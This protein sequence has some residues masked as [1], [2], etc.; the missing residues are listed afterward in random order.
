MFLYPYNRHCYAGLCVKKSNLL[1]LGDGNNCLTKDVTLPRE[2]AR[3]LLKNG[4]RLTILEVPH[5]SMK[6]YCGSDAALIALAFMRKY[7]SG[8]HSPRVII[9]KTERVLDKRE[10]GRDKCNSI[11]CLYFSLPFSLLYAEPRSWLRPAAKSSLR[12]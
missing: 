1:L 2:L 12:G 9:P 3:H 11:D 4:T 10:N 7:Q 8:D 5:I 6:D